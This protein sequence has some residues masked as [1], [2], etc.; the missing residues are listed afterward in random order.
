[1]KKITMIFAI[2]FIALTVFYFTIYSKKSDRG[3][4]SVG[5]KKILSTPVSKGTFFI[6]TDGNGSLCTKAQPCAL[7]ILDMYSKIKINIKAGDIVFFRGG[8]YKYTMK[9]VKRVYLSGGTKGNPVIYESY[10]KEI[11]IFD[12]SL[13]SREDN[14]K[15]EWREGRIELRENYTILR[16]VEIRNMPQYGIRIYGNHNIIEGCNIHHNNLGGI[17]VYNHKDGF[18]I[19]DSGGSYNIIR[20]NTIYANSDVGLI[21]HNYGDGDNADGITI[22]SGIKNIIS[23]NTVY[24]NSDDGIDTWKSMNTIVEYNLVYNQGKGEK[25]NG[26]GIKLGGAGKKSPLGSNNI[27]R[28]NISYSNR[29]SGITTNTGKN[30]LIEYNSVYDNKKFGYTLEND[31]RLNNNVSFKNGDKNVGWDNGAEQN[32]NSWQQKEDIEFIS[33]NPNSSNFLKPTSKTFKNMGVYSEK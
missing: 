12:G 15:K 1:M 4:L 5:A 21:H 32:N 31:T 3:E 29:N 30:V 9:G 6:S 17:Q 22:H 11:A 24:D 10:P 33:L 23:H 13:L 8:T 7:D 27:A 28:Y 25:G 20:N 2:L 14:S 16:K 19:K 26:N 18:S